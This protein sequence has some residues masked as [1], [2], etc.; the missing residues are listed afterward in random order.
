MRP[1]SLTPPPPSSL[2]QVTSFGSDRTK[3]LMFD[4]D[5][6]VDDVD[7]FEKRRSSAYSA[8]NNTEPT[9]DVVAIAENTLHGIS[10][11]DDDKNFQMFQ[12]RF[13]LESSA[14]GRR[15]RKRRWFKPIARA[16]VSI[17]IS[18]AV[19]KFTGCTACGDVA[20]SYASKKL[21]KRRSEMA[22]LVNSTTLTKSVIM[23]G[24]EEDPRRR[25]GT[26]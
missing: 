9:K 8:L 14:T 25:V 24:F 15:R 1:L 7:V 22:D 20:G 18:A 5:K 3:V 2:S 11:L 16:V 17:A 23:V 19:T 4:M 6:V 26:F 12:S 21:V 10:R 13:L